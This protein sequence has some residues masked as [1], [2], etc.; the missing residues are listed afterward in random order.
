M[1]LYQVVLLGAATL[2]VAQPHNHIH[3]HPARHGSP[4]DRRDDAVTTTTVPGPVVTVYELNGEN[5]PWD[6]VES[7]LANGKYVLV[8]DVI[9]TVMQAST[10][11]SSSTSNRHCFLCYK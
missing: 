6:E 5:I 2:T 11:S 1:K 7:G 10:T 3:R 4:L 9:S 8:G